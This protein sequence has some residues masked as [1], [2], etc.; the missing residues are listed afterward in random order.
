MR[1]STKIL[2][3]SLFWLIII[4]SFT[5]I[6]EAYKPNKFITVGLIIFGVLG[7]PFSIN[8][9]FDNHNHGP[10]DDQGLT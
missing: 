1:N 10:P 6:I 4:I 5:A 2:I 9:V 8:I 7:F 3:F